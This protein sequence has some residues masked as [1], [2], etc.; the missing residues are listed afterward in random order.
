MTGSS[1]LPG[2]NTTTDVVFLNYDMMVT[3]S[4]SYALDCGTFLPAPPVHELPDGHHWAF[5]TPDLGNSINE[6]A[7]LVVYVEC[8]EVRKYSCLSAMEAL[9][10]LSTLGLQEWPSDGAF[11]CCRRPQSA[12][13]SDT[14]VDHDIDGDAGLL[15][16]DASVAITQNRALYSG[17]LAFWITMAFHH[18][19]V[20]RTA[21]CSPDPALSDS[22]LTNAINLAEQVFI[23]SVSGST[24]SDLDVST[25]THVEVLKYLCL[26]GSE[27]PPTSVVPQF[28]PHANGAAMYDSFTRFHWTNEIAHSDSSQ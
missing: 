11:A 6:F 1:S 13:N 3:Y 14:I 21:P 9:R 23:T 17:T 19:L 15:C 24:C 22:S 2:P 16:F 12:M 7:M 4:G 25:V 8:L 5:Q 20:S 10:L 27:A 26:P 18:M 28:G